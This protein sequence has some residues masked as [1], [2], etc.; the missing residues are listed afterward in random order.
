M[1]T[2]RIA[3][4]NDFSEQLT[5]YS[6]MLDELLQLGLRELE[7]RQSLTL[8]KQGNVSIWKAAH[9]AKVSLREMIH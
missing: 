8:F 1:Q 2:L 7:M 5:P 9:L 4:S 3:V 6:E